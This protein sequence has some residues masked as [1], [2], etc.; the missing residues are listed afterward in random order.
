M[1]S[2]G[3]CLVWGHTCSFCEWDPRGAEGVGRGRVHP[4]P[5]TPN[6]LSSFS[7]MLMGEERQL[8]KGQRG[9]GTGEHTAHAMCNLTHTK[10]PEHFL[11]SGPPISEGILLV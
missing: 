7:Y 10:S 8:E 11:V 9:E 1:P 3:E 4:G 5:W 6:R 2:L